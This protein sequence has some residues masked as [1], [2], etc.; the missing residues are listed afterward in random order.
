MGPG[1][2]RRGAFGPF[3]RDVYAYIYMYDTDSR[4]PAAG[5]ARRGPAAGRGGRCGP[6]AGPVRDRGGPRGT[7]KG[8]AG[9]RR[10]AQ[11]AWAEKSPVRQVRSATP[12]PPPPWLTDVSPMNKKRISYQCLT[13]VCLRLLLSVYNWR[14]I[15]SY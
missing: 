13:R 3:G 15:S 5:A 2:A 12:K 11:G 7:S 6:A 14:Y 4:S 1:T 9:L 10:A 8:C